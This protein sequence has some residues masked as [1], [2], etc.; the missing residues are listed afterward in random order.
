MEQKSAPLLSPLLYWFLLAMILA[1]IAGNM[2]QLLTPIYLT[3]LGASVAQ[4]GLVFTFTS[5]VVLVLQIVGGWISDSIGRLRAIAIGSI[6]GVLGFIAMLL[7]PSWPWMLLAMAITQ[8][9]YALVGPSFSAFIAENSTPENR[10]RMYGITETIYQVV[11]I[12]GPPLGGVVAGARGFKA[13]LLVATLFYTTAA[14]LRIWMARTMHSAGERER[15]PLTMGAF[16]GSA[17]LIAGMVLGGGLI[18]WIFLT[19]GVRDMA[20]RMSGELEP[21]YLEQIMGL[22]LAQIGLLGSFFSIAM[23]FTPM[24]SGRLVDRYGER[25]P[26][27]G[28]FLVM[29]AAYMVFL[30]AQAYPAFIFTWVLFGL[31]VGLLS[32]AYQSLISKAVPAQTLGAFSGLFYGSMGLIALPAPYIGARIWERFNPQ[33][34]FM[35]TAAVVLLTVIPIWFKFKLAKPVVVEGGIAS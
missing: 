23:A 9:P 29:F 15:Q 20:F 30:Q 31:G 25:V 17:R 35:I 3:K 8:I 14:G 26:I 12:V 13:M 32:P 11:G 34:P 21:L 24:L 16:M 33:V 4:V 7:A 6:G 22:S 2:Y 18:T 10:G 1:N 19:D 5:V 27:A 28:G